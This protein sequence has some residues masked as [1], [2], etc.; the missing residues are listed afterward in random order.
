MVNQAKG[1]RPRKLSFEAK[2]SI[3]IA[4]LLAFGLLTGPPIWWKLTPWG[5]PAQAANGPSAGSVAPTPT[6]PSPSK[7]TVPNLPPGVVG[8]SG[9]CDGYQVFAQN[10]WDP[11]GAV[12]RAAPNIT[13]RITDRFGRNES[14]IVDGWVHGRP[15]YPTNTAPWNSDI[16]LHLADDSGWVSFAGVRET[17]VSYDPT[18]LSK[19]GGTPVP[20]PGKCRGA[21]Q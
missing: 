20:T 13:A 17:P 3:A 2:V 6:G 5:K 21:V 12:A 8:M 9:G 4:V 1:K 14:M 10:R 19:N 15:A 7:A 18:G 11:R 16:W